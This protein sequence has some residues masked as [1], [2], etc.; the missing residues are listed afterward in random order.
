[1]SALDEIRSHMQTRYLTVRKDGIFI[2]TVCFPKMI[3][4]IQNYGDAR[5]LYRGRSPVCRSL[6]GIKP[7]KN[8]DSRCENCLQRNHCTPQIRIELLY[9][10][11]PYRL[12]LSFTSAN[13]FLRYLDQLAQTQIRI[14]EVLTELRVIP[15]YS[16]GEL[17]FH[18][19]PSSC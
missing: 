12:L 5:T 9:Q 15:R 10:Q 19:I 18:K 3:A 8:P 14:Q 7:L 4:K 11:K 6:D 2:G 1:M 16:W 17:T 13:N